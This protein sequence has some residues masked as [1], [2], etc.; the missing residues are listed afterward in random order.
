KVVIVKNNT[1]GQIKWE[2]MVFLGSPEYEVDLQPIDFAELARACGAVGFTVEDPGECARSIEQFL[3]APGPAILQAIVD[4]FEP[5]MPPKVTAEQALHF[6]KSLAR[7][8]P[9]R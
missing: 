1:L 8:E 3:R 2:Q 6:A 9:H 4:P 5:P 7:G